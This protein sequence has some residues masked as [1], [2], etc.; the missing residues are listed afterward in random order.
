[1]LINSLGSVYYQSQAVLKTPKVSAEDLT[2]TDNKAPNSV[3]ESSANVSSVNA[4]RASIVYE[5]HQSLGQQAVGQYLHT[6]Y[7]NQRE[8]ISAAVGI[9]TYA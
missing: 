6:H 8:A 2:S 9:D 1:M 4:S 7:A 3:N 5:R